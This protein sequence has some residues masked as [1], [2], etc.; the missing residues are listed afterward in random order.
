VDR[1][2]RH[3]GIQRRVFFGFYYYFNGDVPAA[4]SVVALTTVGITSAL[5]WVRHFIFHKEDAARLGWET[6]HPDWMLEVG[7]ANLG[8][9]AAALIAVLAKLGP[10]AQ[11]VAIFGYA[12]YLFQAAILH[13]YRYF[14]EEKKN[15]PRLWQ[16]CLLTALLAGMMT[17]FG[18]AGIMA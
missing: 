10:Q 17:F 13:G 15:P 16:F 3:R 14:T 9:G 5:A 12:A 2:I 6:E 4:V 11:A 1:A 8:F 18:I 7:F